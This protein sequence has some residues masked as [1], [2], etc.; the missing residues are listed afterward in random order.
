VYY[1]VSLRT[2]S[3]KVNKEEVIEVIIV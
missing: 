1:V 2:P 3:I